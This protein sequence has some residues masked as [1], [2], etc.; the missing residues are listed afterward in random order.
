MICGVGCRRGS[1]PAWLW[2]WGRP[3]ATTPIRPLAWESPHAMGV[4]LEKA[5]RQKNKKQKNK[6][7]PGERRRSS[8]ILGFWRW[9][10]A[11]QGAV[12]GAPQSSPQ[13]C[14]TLHSP[15]PSPPSRPPS[16]SVPPRAPPPG[17]LPSPPPGAPLGHSVQRTRGPQ[18]V[19]RGGA[20]AWMK[21]LAGRFPS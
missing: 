15:P 11:W 20:R 3:A 14:S 13:S 10:W 17:F 4:A 18:P 5:K 1:D 6:K 9:A 16:S 21:P 19:M 2:L 7:T 12:P 8:G